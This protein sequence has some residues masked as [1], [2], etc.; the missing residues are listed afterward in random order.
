MRGVGGQAATR[1]LRVIKRVTTPP[2][3]IAAA[4]ALALARRVPSPRQRAIAATLTGLLALSVA[5]QMVR[6]WIVVDVALWLGFYA[7]MARGVVVVLRKDEGPARCCLYQLD[8][9]PTA[10]STVKSPKG[11]RRIGR[12]APILL[13]A[14]LLASA[15]V[16]V[17]F[18]VTAELERAA[19]VLALSVQLLAAARFVSRGK[20]PDDAQT[21]ALMLTVSSL[22]DVAGAWYHGDPVRDW[23][24]GQIQ[25]VATWLLI[26]GWEIRC[27][28]RVRPSLT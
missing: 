8:A 2:L 16:A 27:L 7:T 6:R 26:A 17:R 1:L 14:A 12:G 18:V 23:N 4:L 25:A 9:G 28:I 13:L 5:E 19:F 24:V 21:V 20:A 10:S 3:A 15:S 22:A 11:L